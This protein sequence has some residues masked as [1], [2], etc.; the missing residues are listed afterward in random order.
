MQGY[1]TVGFAERELDVEKL[2]ELETSNSRLPC[3]ECQAVR[4]SGETAR[5]DYVAVRS[6]NFKRA[7]FGERI[8]I[9]T[10]R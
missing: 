6:D 9:S 4:C 2:S 7:V 1:I 8:S 3:L 5:I 10:E